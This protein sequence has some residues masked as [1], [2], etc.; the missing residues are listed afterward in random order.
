MGIEATRRSF[1]RAVASGLAA[2]PLLCVAQQAGRGPQAPAPGRGGRF[3]P[4][5][6]RS[7]KIGHT[8]I[9]WPRS[10]GGPADQDKSARE[11]TVPAG[12]LNYPILR[13]ADILLYLADRVPVG[14]DQIPTFAARIGCGLRRTTGR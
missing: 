13:A 1:A 7:M 4:H 11:E 2:M 10:D 12:L 6:P 9:T 14:E 8:G 3:A 5:P